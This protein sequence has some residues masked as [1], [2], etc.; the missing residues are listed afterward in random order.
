MPSKRVYLSLGSNLGD[1]KQNLE[2][3][4]QALEREDIQ[5]IARSS[6]YETEPQ[7]VIQQPWFV[8]MVVEC[9]T[10]RFPLQLLSILHRIEREMGRVRGTGAL[11]SGPRA[12]DIDILLFGNITMDTPRLIIPHPRMLTRRFVLKPL[13]EIAPDLRDPQ[14]KKP[15]SK[16]LAEVA[17]QKVSKLEE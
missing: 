6:L 13:L 8:N 9:E 14:T 16:Y 4:L 15:L 11:R 1:R 3:A 7:D 5:I 12:I 17:G 10:Q 2:H